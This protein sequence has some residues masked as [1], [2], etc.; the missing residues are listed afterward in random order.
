M[1]ITAAHLES[2]HEQFTNWVVSEG[3]LRM[4]EHVIVLIVIV[5]LLT[6]ALTI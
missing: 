4:T 1:N 3:W 6:K 2:C 5:K